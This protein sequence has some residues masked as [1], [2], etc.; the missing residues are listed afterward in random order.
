MSRFSLYIFDL[1]GT[2]VDTLRVWSQMTRTFL[3]RC[4]LSATDG[5]ISAM[6]SMT[7]QQGYAHMCVQFGLDM[8]YD[9]FVEVW[10]ETAAELY[11]REAEL[12]PDALQT[13]D[14]L[15]RQGAKLALFSQSPRPLVEEVLTENGLWRRFDGIF[16]SGETASP[17][18]TP[19]AVLEVVSAM[20]ALPAQAALVDDAAYAAAA[21]R[22]AGVFAYGVGYRNAKRAELEPQADAM[23]E[24]LGDLR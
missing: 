18:G 16:L 24:A 23:L 10:L 11:A 3:V 7:F 20:G 6:D 4:G 13:L 9:R 14:A 5:E 15:R 8:P 22:A 19:E 1:D 12:M 2:L 21:A 17:K